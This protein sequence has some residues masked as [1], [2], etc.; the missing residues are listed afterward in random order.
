MKYEYVALVEMEGKKYNAITL[1]GLYGSKRTVDTLEDAQKALDE[2]VSYLTG[3][4]NKTVKAGN[5]G[6]TA[7]GYSMKVDKT[8]IKKRQ[9]TEWE[10]IE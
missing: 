6:I 2:Y 1:C 3:N 10:V 5:I 9:V 7:Q 4:K 8:Y